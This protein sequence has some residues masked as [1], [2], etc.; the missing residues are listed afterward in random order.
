MGSRRI[1]KFASLSLGEFF[2]L[3]RLFFL[4][5]LV[6]A[7]IRTLTLP[8]LA[9]RLGIE[10]GRAEDVSRTHAVEFTAREREQVVMVDRL[11]RRWRLA[12][13]PCLRRSL[14]IGYLLR[15]HRPTLR[16][17]TQFRGTFE[18]HAWLEIGGERLGYLPGFEEFVFG[19]A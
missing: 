8:R 19:A 10:V 4:T 15:H 18:A 12:R 7:G 3:L 17:G 9:G 14:V 16:I 6:E 11:M 5:C 2:L 13:G 1:P